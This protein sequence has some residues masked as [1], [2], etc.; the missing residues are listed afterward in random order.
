VQAA[1]YFQKALAADPGAAYLHYPLAM[2]YRGMGQ[3]DK[4]QAELN[5]HGPAAPSMADPYLAEIRDLKSGKA[6]LWTRGSQQMS[7]GDF[8]AAIATYRSLVELDSKDALAHTYFGTAL[9]RAGN[10]GDALRELS[11]AAELT[12]ANANV[13][14]CLGVVLVRVGRDAEAI[15]HLRRALDGDPHL[16]E[17]HFQLANALMRNRQFADAAAEYGYAR[18]ENRTNG[19]AAVMQALAFVKLGDYA[20]AR[21]TLES[22]HTLMPADADITNALSRILAAAPDETLRDGKRAVEIMQETIAKTG[23]AD[24]EQAATIAMALAEIGQFDKARQIQRKVVEE[25]VGEAAP[26]QMS[27]LRADLD[28]YEHHRA[29]RVPWREDDPIFV[30][31][32]GTA[33]E[34]SASLPAGPGAG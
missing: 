21:S 3:P 30:P 25:M 27:L 8:G 32:P 29:C 11:E 7:A 33:P 13:Q 19:F 18:N 9:A 17:A 28:A 20:N 10:T 1:G 6:D 5:L 26:G 2:A 34:L 14:Y 15:E 4:A 31:T 24:L 22:A 16:K 23:A 12:P